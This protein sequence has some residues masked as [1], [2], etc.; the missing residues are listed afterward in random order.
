MA[1]LRRTTLRFPSHRK[2]FGTAFSSAN[3][4][5]GLLRQQAVRGP[6]PLLQLAKV[7]PGTDRQGAPCFCTRCLTS[8]GTRPACW[9]YEIML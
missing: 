2:G 1:L 5:Q 8:P 6:R 7:K 9:G 4:A 3:P